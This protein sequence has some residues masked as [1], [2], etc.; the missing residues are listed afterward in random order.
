MATENTQAGGSLKD[1]SDD[2]KKISTVESGKEQLSERKVTESSGGGL[3]D[4]CNIDDII[5][6]R[7]SPP[8]QHPIPECSGMK[9]SYVLTVLKLLKI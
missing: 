2:S 3:S 9:I 4:N 1:T 5:K 6:G 8:R 7:S